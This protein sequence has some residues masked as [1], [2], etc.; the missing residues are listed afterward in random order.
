M[1]AINY[2]L[3]LDILKD[4]NDEPKITQRD[5]MKKYDVTERTVRRYIK[6][7]KDEKILKLSATGKERKWKIMT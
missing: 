4:I 1:K 5:L 6:I 2:N 7:L 3:L